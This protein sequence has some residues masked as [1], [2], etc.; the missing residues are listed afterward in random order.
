MGVGI[1]TPMTQYGGNRTPDEHPTN[2][3]R[4]PDEHPTN[5]RRTPREHKLVL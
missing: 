3:Q 1:P 2:T 5:T 4:T